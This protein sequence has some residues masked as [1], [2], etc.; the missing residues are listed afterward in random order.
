M[1]LVTNHLMNMKMLF[2]FFI[3][4]QFLLSCT[5]DKVGESNSLDVNILADVYVKNIFRFY[6]ELGTFYSIE[7]ADNS[8]L[9]DNS[10]NGLEVEKA[11]ED[12]LYALV[13]AVDQEKLSRKD[14]IT[15]SILK[16]SLESSIDTRV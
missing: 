3:I 12:S 1:A 8:S 14:L 10:I 6:P 5:K 13:Q 4:C 15:Y 16:E 7:N 2:I 9:S 11:S